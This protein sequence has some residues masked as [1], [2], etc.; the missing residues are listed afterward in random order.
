[1]NDSAAGAAGGDPRVTSHPRAETAQNK[2]V[3]VRTIAA[4]AAAIAQNTVRAVKEN[5]PSQEWAAEA[6]RI[7]LRQLEEPDP[8]GTRLPRPSDASKFCKKWGAALSKHGSVADAP[9]SGRKRKLPEDAVEALVKLV[10]EVQPRTQLEMEEHFAAYRS[11][12]NVSPRTIWRRIKE[13]EPKLGK[14][15]LVEYKLPLTSEVK[16]QRR[17]QCERWLQLCSNQPTVQV[18]RPHPPIT[19]PK[20]LADL[21]VAM[22]ERIIWVDAKKFYV[23]PKGHKRWGRRGTR[24]IVVQDKR[25]Q[26]AWVIHYYSAVNYKHGGLQANGDYPPKHLR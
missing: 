26:G 5:R 9:R 2:W 12:H 18:P 23:K 10:E 22:L 13:S 25:A 17:E 24:S 16:A 3:P 6:G 1:M 19:I 14:H 11:A 20:E 4:K 21:N 15:V 8:T 7:L